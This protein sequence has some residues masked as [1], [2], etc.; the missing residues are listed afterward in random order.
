MLLSSK[1][2]L[3]KMLPGV[4]ETVRYPCDCCMTYKNDTL[5]HVIIH[6][7]DTCGWSRE[8]VADWIETLD[9]D[10]T[11]KSEPVEIK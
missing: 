10:T 5:Y 4:K 1:A 2:F 11:F 3:A 9:V 6:L 7:N 8:R